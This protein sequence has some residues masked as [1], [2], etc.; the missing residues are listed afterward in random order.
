MGFN[1]NLKDKLS[2]F[3]GA[4]DFAVQEAA[5]LGVTKFKDFIVDKT[6]GEFNL[7]VF[8]PLILEPLVKKDL[9]L[10][11]LRIDDIKISVS[12]SKNIIKTAIE[13]RNHTI[14]EHISNGDFTISMEGSIVEGG[15][16]KDYPKGKLFLLKQFLNAPYSL[17]V[18]HA[19]LNR[20]GIFQIVF[21]SYTVPSIDGVKNVQKF[22]ANA[23]SDEP[24]E[25]IIRDNV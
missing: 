24:I 14:K 12:Q 8:A 16:S 23:V 2:Q 1:I 17:N 13:G 18:T 21:E 4:F 22:S 11:P 3:D 25:L 7:P 15:F 9:V 6:G 20:L 19:I 10:P 5:D